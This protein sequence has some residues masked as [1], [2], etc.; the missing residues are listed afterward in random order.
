M[1]ISQKAKGLSLMALM[2][3]VALL[4]GLK[5]KRE[6]D[7]GLQIFWLAEL[8]APTAVFSIGFL[9]ALEILFKPVQAAPAPPPRARRRPAS[10]KAQR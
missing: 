1:A 3:L 2:A 5:I 9:T 8:W 6:L 10:K 7:Q 4:W